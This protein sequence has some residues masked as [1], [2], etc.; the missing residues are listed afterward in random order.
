[1][2]DT[3]GVMEPEGIASVHILGFGEGALIGTVLAA[4]HP[5]WVRSLVLVEAPAVG[6]R[7]MSSLLI[8]D[9]T[10]GSRCDPR[11]QNST[12]I[13]TSSHLRHL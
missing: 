11:Q 2:A 7:Q 10:T 8:P 13:E 9:P 4:E 1:M 6:G 12:S 5:E 3:L